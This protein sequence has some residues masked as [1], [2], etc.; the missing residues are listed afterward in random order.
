VPGE[1]IVVRHGAK[2]AVA[3]RSGG[4]SAVRKSDESDG[5]EKFAKVALRKAFDVARRR[6][7]DRLRRTRGL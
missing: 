5:D 4:R 6:L 1:D 7:Q 2:Q 3:V